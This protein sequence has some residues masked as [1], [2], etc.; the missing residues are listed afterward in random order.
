ME[1]DYFRLGEEPHPST[2]RPLK[3]LRASFQVCKSPVSVPSFRGALG[4]GLVWVQVHDLHASGW[5]MV[6]ERWKRDEDYSYTCNQLK[7]I[8]Q[9]LRVQHIENDF[10]VD[11]SPSL[12]PA[13][14]TG[15]VYTE[16][17]IRVGSET[18]WLRFS[19]FS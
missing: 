2:I 12:G 16:S 15:R 11:V 18:I 19:C 7:S 10:T 1:K 9:D 6:K 8:R 14:H 3:V 4:G 13:A 5:Q 17:Q